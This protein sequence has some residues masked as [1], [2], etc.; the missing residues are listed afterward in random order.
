MSQ[1]VAM[2]DHW[3]IVGWVIWGSH[4]TLT[5][6]AFFSLL[7]FGVRSMPAKMI[8]LSLPGV[9]TTSVALYR[10][11]AGALP[12]TLMVAAVTIAALA[13]LTF[14]WILSKDNLISRRTLIVSSGL[15]FTGVCCEII[16][17]FVLFCH[18]PVSPAYL[19]ILAAILI[20]PSV[21]NGARKQFEIERDRKN[22]DELTAARTREFEQA[23]AERQLA[24]EQMRRAKNFAEEASRAKSGFLANISHEMR[25]PLN[26]IVGMSE[27]LL[28]TQK[29]ESTRSRA[30][31]IRVSADALLSV[32]NDVLDFSKIEAGRMQIDPYPLD[33]PLLLTDTLTIMKPLA[34]AKRI[35]FLTELDPYLPKLVLCD[36]HRLRQILLN[37]MGNAIKFTNTG[38][39]ALRVD[40]I[41]ITDSIARI[42][43]CCIDTGIGISEDV[44]SRLFKPFEQADGTITRRFGG[45]GLGL[46]I[47]RYLVEAMGGRLDLE[48]EPFS[49][50]RFF[51]TLDF[52]LHTGNDF[53]DGRNT[54]TLE[55][56]DYQ[57]IKGQNILLAEDNEINR[58]VALQMLHHLHIEADCAENG[59]IA[60]EKATEKKYDLIFMDV[61]MPEM[62]G[63]R[64]A[65]LLRERGFHGKIIA[66]T[67]NTSDTDRTACLESGMDGFLSKPVTLRSLTAALKANL[68][69]NKQESKMGYTSG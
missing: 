4:A 32:I 36:G 39:V 5:A 31:M 45:T 60:V 54:G 55:Y 21:M 57:L 26:A 66:M 42:Q 28:D 64:A 50:S 40:P 61:Q 15:W 24:F 43:F 30:K 23:A 8:L 38:F 49:G 34:A 53:T 52:S 11:R 6:F 29:D 69:N 67:A 59:Q 1:W 35:G 51:F 9:F 3:Q 58:E 10:L 63:L 12:T 18:L 56:A 33:L 68:S 46:S 19:L 47:S 7:L 2:F 20:G 13:S 16:F 37:L 65:K 48:S 14:L 44:R 41:K 25:T 27:L 62:D 17:C 22:L